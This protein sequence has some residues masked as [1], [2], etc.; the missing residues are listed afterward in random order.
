M[1]G[2]RNLDTCNSSGAQI[3]WWQWQKWQNKSDQDAMHN[4]KNQLIHEEHPIHG[5]RLPKKWHVKDQPATGNKL[6]EIVDRFTELYKHKR[7]KDNETDESGRTKS[8]PTSEQQIAQ[9]PRS[10]GLKDSSSL[11]Q[12]DS[13][14]NKTGEKCAHNKQALNEK[15]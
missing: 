9:L 5:R 4:H 7:Y 6:S 12:N 8:I 2:Y 13:R 11:W 3:Q 15:L 14:T 1:W 10:T